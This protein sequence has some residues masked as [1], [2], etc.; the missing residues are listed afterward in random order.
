MEVV[1]DKNET[2]EPVGRYERVECRGSAKIK[3]SLEATEVVCKGRLEAEELHAVKVKAKGLKCGII[4]V[5][6]LITDF[7]DAGTVEVK[8]AHIRGPMRVSSSVK[9]G[10]LKVEGSLS[11]AS[12]EAEKAKISGSFR[13]MRANV[14]HLEV[15]GSI[16]VDEGSIEYALVGGS[17][18]LGSCKITSLRVGGTLRVGGSTDIGE[19]EAGMAEVVGHLT[20]G[21][22]KVNEVLKV[23]GEIRVRILEVGGALKVSGSIFAE[24]AHVA[25][26]GKGKLAGG[27]IMVVGEATE[28][29]G[30]EIELINARVSRVT[31]GRVRVRDSSVGTISAVEVEVMGRSKVSQITAERVYVSG[32]TVDKV[33]YTD[34]LLVSPEAQVRLEKR[35]AGL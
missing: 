20:G 5:D 10:E 11:C 31:G 9:A 23:E 35:V 7:L 16:E 32:G 21:Q 3:G 15:R 13:A 34:K 8:R 24:E 12:F 14:K 4:E 29:E 22:L 1:I 2:F 27:R 26:K 19:A 17:A 33:Y 25:G 18:K 6:E 30:E 28:V